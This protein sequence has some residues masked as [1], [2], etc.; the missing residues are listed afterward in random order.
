MT[1]ITART[2]ERSF[3]LEKYSDNVLEILI[4]V[5]LN[6]YFFL[7]NYILLDILWDNNFILQFSVVC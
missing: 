3:Y 1:M 6:I 7:R 2:A 5:L 4:V